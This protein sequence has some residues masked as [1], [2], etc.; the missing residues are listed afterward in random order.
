MS[1]NIGKVVLA[2]SGGLDTSVMIKWLQEKYGAEVYTLTLDLGQRD[3][4]REIED[5]AYKIGAKQ[6]FFVD[7]RAEFV[8]RFV[9]PAIKANGFYE[10]KYPLSTALG[11]PL[12]SEKLVEIAHKVGADAVA[13]G[14]TGK[15]NDQVRFDI[16][17]R[18]L[19]P[20]LKVLVP[21][22]D[23]GLSRD[24][25][26]EYAKSKGLPVSEKKSKYS[27]DQNLWGRSI[28]SGPLED[29]FSEPEEDVYDWVT[30]PEKAPDSP[31]YVTLTFKQG[32]PVEIDGERLPPV[33]LIQ[34]LNT[35]AGKNGVGLVDHIEDRLVGIKSREVYEVPAALT[36]LEAHRDLEKLTLTVHELSAKAPLED[37]W[38]RLVYNGLWLEPL[39]R[40]IDAFIEST[41]S[42]VSGDVK[43]KFY[44]GHLSV[45]GR[46]SENS[47]YR[48]EMSTYAKDSKY[49]QQLAVGFIELWGMQTITANS[50]RSKV[51]G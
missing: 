44:K 45:V 23:W 25:E 31:K 12:I 48:R 49:N 22:R 18:A 13:H 6:H 33:D 50:V 9:Y 2:Y 10:G 36:I 29:P 42:V 47:L 14:S 4:F 28:E 32:V 38:S 27:V 24:V 40:H 8:E 5:R 15:G 34:R 51:A 35:I 43:L 26:L 11:R 7:A 3:D 37:T 19:D 20:G 30:P 46:R 39:R 17:V 16:T 1:S 21:V 41:Q